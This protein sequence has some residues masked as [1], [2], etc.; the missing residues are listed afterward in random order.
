MR[1]VTPHDAATP[2]GSTR[3]LSRDYLEDVLAGLFGGTG[4]GIVLLVNVLLLYW[5][6]PASAPRRMGD[7]AMWPAALGYSVGWPL[8][9]LV[10]G[11]LGRFAR[12]E[13]TQRCVAALAM[14]A[15][16][17]PLCVVSSNESRGYCLGLLFWFGVIGAV[18]MR[19][20]F[21]GELPKPRDDGGYRGAV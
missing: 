1:E 10:A 16:A 7:L 5:L 17:I 19:G 4:I 14:A 20:A 12:H 2:D 8:A 13:A 11:A 21:F 3:L 18:A 9:G 15:Y 6:F